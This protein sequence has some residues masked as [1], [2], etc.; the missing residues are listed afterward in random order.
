MNI[1]TNCGILTPQT[2]NTFSF[3]GTPSIEHSHIPYFHRLMCNWAY[4]IAQQYSWVVVID[5][6]SKQN[7][8][9]KIKETVPTYEPVGWDIKGAVD[10]TW[11]QETQDTIGCIFA[12]G[13][14][15][16]GENLNIER[17]GI[18][19]GS[20][21][22]FINA[23]IANGRAD[24]EDLQISFLETNQ[25]FVDGVIRPWNIL[26]AHE[27]LIAR[28]EGESIKA[29]I[30]IYQLAKAGET[31]KNIIRKKITFN[32][33]VPTK[34]SSEQLVYGTSDIGK[35]QCYFV[36]NSYTIE[37]YNSK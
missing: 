7:L 12:Q 4:N 6:I 22:G 5:A 29:N 34:V 35:R 15:L 13:V 23:P 11:T 24:F 2:F 32:E 30:V 8:L 37:S 26:V 33:A 27:G 20:R 9:T 3:D 31:T 21:R 1:L 36:F 28:N 18:T 19:E 17:V 25:S 14:D 16:P 10:S